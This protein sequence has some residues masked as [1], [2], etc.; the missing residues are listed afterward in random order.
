MT[1][2]FTVPCVVFKYKEYVVEKGNMLRL[3]FQCPHHLNE[4]KYA[5]Q[6]YLLFLFS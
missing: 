4:V 3:Y 1:F 6:Y 2:Y 5:I